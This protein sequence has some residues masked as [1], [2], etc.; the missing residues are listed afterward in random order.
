MDGEPFAHQLWSGFKCSFK[1]G[2]LTFSVLIGGFLVL[3]AGMMFYIAARNGGIDG[4]I[5]TGVMAI[6]YGLP[7]LL[8]YMVLITG[9]SLAFGIVGACIFVI[10]KRLPY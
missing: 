5:G 3:F 9:L 6:I 4:I 8:Y 7:T 2:C 1:Y 10:W